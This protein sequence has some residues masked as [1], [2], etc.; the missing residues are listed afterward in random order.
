MFTDKLIERIIDMKNH[1][2]VG[3]DPHYNII[4][5]YLKHRYQKEGGQSLDSIA[6]MLYEFSKEIIDHIYDIVPAVK[7]Q[8]AFF[9]R[10]GS[11]GL[12]AF[13]RVCSYAKEKGLLVIADVKRGDIGSTCEAYSQ[14]YLGDG[15]GSVSCD[16]ITVNPYLGKDSINPFAERCI[17]GDKGIFILVKT[18]NKSSID[19][20]DLACGEKKIYEHAA[21]L[22]NSIGKGHEGSRGYNSIGAVV[23]GTFK[24][25]GESLRNIMKTSYFLVPGF[26]AQ[27]GKASDLPGYFNEDGLGSIINSSRGIIGAYLLDRYKS[28]FDDKSY[29]AAARRAAIDMRNEINKHL[30]E[31]NKVVW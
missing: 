7:P 19:I 12:K 11:F 30:E 31:N 13:E 21:E 20:Q 24:E 17:N 27:G 9:E 28:D 2:I 16:A 23:G 4:P 8:I 10:Y 22:V 25:E 3:I 18:S 14:Y 5:D 15:I 26:G 1:C 6:E 29:G